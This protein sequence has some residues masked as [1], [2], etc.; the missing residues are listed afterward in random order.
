MNIYEALKESMDSR[1]GKQEGFAFKL[2]RKT[3]PKENMA[4][5]KHGR[6]GNIC[7]DLREGIPCRVAFAFSIVGFTSI[8]GCLQ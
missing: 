5:G 6:R 1:S 8:I 7:M 3:W 2:R 4:E